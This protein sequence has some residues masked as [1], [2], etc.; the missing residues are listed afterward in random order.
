MGS[1]ATGAAATALVTGAVGC[2][3]VMGGIL[4]V[5]TAAAGY[6]LY[7]GGQVVWKWVSD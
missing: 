4:I 6:G 2:P 7:K 3:V 1:S 5:G